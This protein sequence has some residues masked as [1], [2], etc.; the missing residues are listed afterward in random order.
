MS[1]FNNKGFAQAPRTTDTIFYSEHAW[2]IGR[3]IPKFASMCGLGFELNLFWKSI[4]YLIPSH[5]LILNISSFRYIIRNKSHLISPLNRNVTV[6]NAEDIPL[7]IYNA[8]DI[9]P[10]TYL[11]RKC[12]GA[13]RHPPPLSVRITWQNFNLRPVYLLSKYSKNLLK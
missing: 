9:H 5:G 13:D 4:E 8:E 3:L 10:Q 2:G 7:Q 12:C 6:Y 11:K 1:K